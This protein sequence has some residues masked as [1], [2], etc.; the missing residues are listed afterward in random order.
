MAVGKLR[1]Q[2][3]SAGE[4]KETR[5]ESVRVVRGLRHVNVVVGVDGLLRAELTTEELDGTVGDDLREGA[6]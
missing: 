1:E 6:A 2:T 5:E 3:E 4:G